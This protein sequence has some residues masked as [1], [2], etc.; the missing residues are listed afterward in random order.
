MYNDTYF[1]KPP[2]THLKQ[3]IDKPSNPI[4]KYI[5]TE[6][7][8]KFPTTHSFHR[9]TKTTPHDIIDNTINKRLLPQTTNLDDCI[10]K[11]NYKL[12]FILYIP[13]ETLRARW[14]L[15]QVDL[16]ITLKLTQSTNLTINVT[17]SS[18]PSITEIK[19]KAKNIVDGGQNG[20]H[21]L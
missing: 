13:E 10:K 11:S 17:V 14:Y 16:N 6:H 18:M 3:R 21:K 7:K 20:G 4:N 1:T 15:I 2:P 5:Q 12:F 19:I 9:E 8:I